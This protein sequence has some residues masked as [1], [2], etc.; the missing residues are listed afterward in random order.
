M[1]WSVH[2]VPLPDGD[3]PADLWV[4]E[5]GCLASEQ[6]PAAEM[7]VAKLLIDTMSAEEFDPEKFHDMYREDVMAMIDAR[8]EGRAVPAHE[9]K[10][11]AASNVVNLMDVL[12]RSLEQSKGRK[13]SEKGAAKEPAR[14]K[15]AA[16]AAKPKRK[17]S[18]A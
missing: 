15:T 4:D 10:R 5:A 7:K 17:K 9:P 8:I 6:V 18:A 13:P 14:K 2:A 16:N 11:P 3:R 1:S 12:Q